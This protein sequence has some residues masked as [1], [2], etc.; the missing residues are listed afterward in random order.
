VRNDLELQLE[1]LR[2]SVVG[3]GERAD[4]MLASALRTLG[5]G[6]ASA[7]DQV[8]ELEQE[9][10]RTYEQVQHGVLALVALHAPVGRDLRLLTAMIHVSI[11]AERMADYA[12]SVAR[13]ALRSAGFPADADLIDQ[14]RE[15]GDL[16]RE[17]ARA[18]FQAFVR[19]DVELAH[20]VARLDDGVDRL[21]LGIF[22]RLVRLAAQ[23]E[24]RI[25][26]A[27]RMIQLTRQL[28]RFADHGVDIAEQ[29][30]FAATGQAIELSSNDQA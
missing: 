16:A 4:E 24:G 13:T 19:G 7:I 23:D 20:Q 3:M 28:E 6:D 22:G 30:V 8:M 21:N 9:V 25:E 27:G 17:V 18:A 26:W 11:H 2:N 12:V 15:M 10:D 29:A 14:L 5:D 1:K